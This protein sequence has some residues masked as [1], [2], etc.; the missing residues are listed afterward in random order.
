MNKMLVQILVDLLATSGHPWEDQKP[1]G[2]T[3]ATSAEPG[4][5]AAPSASGLHRSLQWTAAFQWHRLIASS[6]TAQ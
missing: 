2:Q 1:A 4:E 6:T 3:N 5:G